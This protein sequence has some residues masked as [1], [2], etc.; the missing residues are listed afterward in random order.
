MNKR[1]KINLT[2][3]FIGII[4]LLIAIITIASGNHMLNFAL[5]RKNIILKKNANTDSTMYANYPF[6]RPWVDSLNQIRAMKDT[7]IT[8][9]EGIRLHANYIYAASPTT[10]TAVI[11]HGYTDNARRMLMIGYLYNHDLGYNILLP[12]LYAH[13]FSGGKTIQ[14]GWKDRLDV[15]RW[16]K[17]A[18][19]IFGDSTQMVV[20]GIS[21]GAAATM[22]V[23]GEKQP[24][25]VKC[26]IEDC[27]YTSVFDEFAY[28]LKQMFGLPPFPILYTANSI[29]Q[30]CYGWNFKEASALKQV[31]KCHLPML[32]IHGD[33]D[34]YVPTWMAFALYK[35]K[36]GTKE[37][38]IVPGAEHAKSYLIN[39][40]KYSEKVHRFTTKYM[41]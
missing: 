18:N 37:L 7:F 9:N 23:S 30:I 20:H 8:N 6:L 41:R 5:L 25:Y 10:H 29:C 27:G 28:Q 16:M 38:W 1:K 36:P 21:M 35:A 3:T 24:S 11:V 12:D 39:K 19:H 22:M 4:V 31:M 2:K 14:M 26:F 17:V 33:K 15:I 32:F 34:T 40:E 13:G